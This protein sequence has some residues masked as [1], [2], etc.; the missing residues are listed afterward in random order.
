LYREE[1]PLNGLTSWSSLI[2]MLDKLQRVWPSE[3]RTT[4]NRHKGFTMS[5]KNLALVVAFWAMAAAAPGVAAGTLFSVERVNIDT[6]LDY[7][8]TESYEFSA[9]RVSLGGDQGGVGYGVSYTLGDED[10]DIDPFGFPFELEIE[11]VL[12]VYAVIGDQFRLRGGLSLWDT[13]YTDQ[14]FGISDSDTVFTFD[15]GLGF[16]I[17][18][19]NNLNLFG[20]YMFYFGSA[21]YDSFFS[22]SVD[23]ESTSL[24]IG[25]G[26]VF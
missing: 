7:S 6:D 3:I 15:F 2:R 20:D 17:D 19:G 14:T 10:D 9:L 5:P 16:N 12:S 24:S 13:R 25:L 1:T 21:D 26:I 18:I 23:F 11:S 22:S 4:D 8:E